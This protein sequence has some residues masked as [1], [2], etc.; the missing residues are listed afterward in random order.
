MTNH[1]TSTLDEIL[2]KYKIGFVVGDKDVQR[3]LDEFKQ[4]I[5]TLLVKARIDEVKRSLHRGYFIPEMEIYA[6]DRI[7]E[8]EAQL[9]PK[10]KSGE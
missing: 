1:P 5:A 6:E 8:L 10:E 9:T 7:A 2:A 4:A 3:H